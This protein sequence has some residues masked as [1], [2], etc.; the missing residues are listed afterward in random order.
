MHQER[1]TCPRQP[2][3]P[4]KVVARKGMWPVRQRKG[5]SAKNA[6]ALSAS[7]EEPSMGSR[8]ENRLFPHGIDSLSTHYLHPLR[9]L[10]Q[11]RF[12]TAHRLHDGRLRLMTDG[13]LKPHPLIKTD[14]L[15]R[16]FGKGVGEILTQ[17][18]H[19]RMIE[20]GWFVGE[21]LF[22][23]TN[24]YSEAWLIWHANYHPE[25]EAHDLLVNMF[26]GGLLP[27][28]GRV[29]GMGIAF[30]EHPSSPRRATSTLDGDAALERL[31]AA[32][33]ERTAWV[34]LVSDV[35]DYGT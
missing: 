31:G 22:Q 9:A 33:A 34:K 18:D 4:G 15:E 6:T 16:A 3:I 25:T 27:R 2:A 7:K 29:D 1:G 20:N 21:D 24:P 11:V 35:Y 30:A 28:G 19:W 5:S 10:P 14:A 13:P 12:L 32:L 8:S 26:G 17:P 23:P